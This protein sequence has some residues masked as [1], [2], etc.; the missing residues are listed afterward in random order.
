MDGPPGVIYSKGVERK[1]DPGTDRVKK[2]WT[3]PVTN[4]TEKRISKQNW[5]YINY[6]QSGGSYNSFNARG[7][8]R[9]VKIA[10]VEEYIV[11]VA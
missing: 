6:L 10:L 3:Q 5:L 11:S 1:F 7:P 8:E 9:F 4:L 2:S